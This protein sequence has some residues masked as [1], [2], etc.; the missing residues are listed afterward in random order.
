[1]KLYAFFVA[2]FTTTFSTFLGAQECN[3]FYR[4]IEN[5]TYEYGFF[6]AKD[7]PEGRQLYRV[8][9]ITETGDGMT[10]EVHMKFIP[11]KK[12]ADTFEADSRVVCKGGTLQMDFAMTMSQMT[13]QFSNM[14]MTMEGDALQI[15]AKLTAGET[16]PDAETKIK[17]GMNGMS[18]MSMTLSI[19]DRKVEG[20]ES[21]TTPAGTFE[22][23]KITQTTSMKSIM[24][25]SYQSVE[26]YAE[27]VGLVQSETYDKKG[28]L[29]N[30]QVLLSIEE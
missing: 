19:T 12:N 17:T 26:Y 9:N 29:E 22:C 2:V 28:K 5:A 13:S 16:L 3:T 10:A 23:Y 7:K 6:D 25:K 1:M 11:E 30:K 14:E 8:G 4:F 20:K 21:I 18:L 24:S 15:P 27:G